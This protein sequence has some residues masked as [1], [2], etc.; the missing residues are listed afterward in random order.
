[1]G[2]ETFYGDGLSKHQFCNITSF[3]FYCETLFHVFLLA[4]ICFVFRQSVEMQPFAVI[5]VKIE[6]NVAFDIDI[7]RALF[8]ALVGSQLYF[9]KGLSNE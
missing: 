3:K 9:K 6:P 4:G 8:S 7:V 1:M 2:N 5:Q